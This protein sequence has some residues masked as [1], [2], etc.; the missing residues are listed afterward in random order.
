[1]NELFLSSILSQHFLESHELIFRWLL[2]RIGR[3]IPNKPLLHR[4][5]CAFEWRSTRNVDLEPFS[6]SHDCRYYCFVYYQ[7]GLG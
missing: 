2:L 4:S 5:I 7:Q 6:F 1:M 3:S